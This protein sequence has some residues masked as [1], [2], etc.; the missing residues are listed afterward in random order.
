MIATTT[1]TTRREAVAP[2]RRPPPAKCCGCCG[3]IIMGYVHICEIARL[4]HWGPETERHILCGTCSDAIRS[5]IKSRPVG[6]GD[7]L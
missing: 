5:F 2:A 4:T 7:E 1:T 6:G 3:S